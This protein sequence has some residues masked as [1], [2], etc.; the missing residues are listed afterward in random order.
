MTKLLEPI[1]AGSLIL[2]H[3][4]IMP[5]MAT[6]KAEADGRVSQA[7]LD[8]YKEKTAGGYLS[9]VIIE[10][11]FIE[12]KGKASKN[13]LSVAE[14]SMIGDLKHLAEVIHQNGSKTMM[15]INHAGSAASS[16]VT[17]Y[18]PVA[19]SAII[20]PRTGGEL[21]HEL[22]QEEIANIVQAFK[23]AARRTK[24]AGFDGVEI[25]SAHGYLLNQFLSPLTNKRTDEYGGTLENR[26]RL[27]LQVI[28]AVRAEVGED[29]P[30]LLRLGA[31]DFMEGGTTLEDS[32]FAAREFEKAGI[33]ILDISAGLCGYIRPAAEGKF[34]E[35]TE[36]IKNA[37]SIPVILTGGITQIE[38]A[39][40]LLIDGKADLIGVGRAIL[41]DSKWAAE[42]IH[43]LKSHKK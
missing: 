29:Y 42:G 20:N 3:R 34:P 4:L 9:L 25:H 17:G 24:E 2:T 16:E 22:T 27:H 40:Q 41:H 8:Y 35:L 43:I 36:G 30:L 12:Q 19:P 32:Q 31:S 5:P 39:E 26:I 37:V 10:H 33:S 13:Q 6:S 18:S 7:I 23:N 1:Q 21:P 28:K 15:Q 38:T 14:N 11:S